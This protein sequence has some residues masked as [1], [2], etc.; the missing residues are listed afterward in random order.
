MPGQH[1]LIEQV[2]GLRVQPS[3]AAAAS[4]LEAPGP[5]GVQRKRHAFGVRVAPCVAKDHGQAQRHQLADEG[6]VVLVQV[7]L[8]QLATVAQHQQ[9]QPVQLVDRQAQH[10]SVVKNVGAVFVVVAVRN[11]DADFMQLGGP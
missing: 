3:P 2:G 6:R 7:K 5:T 1:F 9:A 10:V 4:Q 11:L 8:A